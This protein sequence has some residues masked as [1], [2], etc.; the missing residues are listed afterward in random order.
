MAV[1]WAVRQL[2]SS[3]GGSPFTVAVAIGF[4]AVAG[5]CLQLVEL[6][7]EVIHSLSPFAAEYFQSAGHVGVNRISLTPGLTKSGLV[8]LVGYVTF[9]TTMLHVLRDR[10]VIDTVLRYVALSA[11]MM[12]VIGIAQMIAGNGEFLWVFKHPLRSA[13]G[14]AKGTFTNQNHFAHFLALGVGPLIWCWLNSGLHEGTNVR[15]RVSN[16]GF[17]VR[18]DTDVIQM[19]MAVGIGVVALAGILSMSRGGIAA[20]LVAFC[21]SLFAAGSQPAKVLR[22]CMS[23]G[24][25]FRL[26][27]PIILLTIVG[28]TA[29]GTEILEARWA[30]LSQAQ[31][32]QDLSEGRYLLWAALWK[33]VPWFWPLGSGVGSH[34][35]VYPTWLEEDFGKRFSHAESGY[36]QVLIETGI[37]GLLLVGLAIF[38]VASWFFRVWRAGN[39]KDR[40]RS[41]V[42][43]S[44]LVVSSLHSVADFVWYIPACMVLTL[45]LAACL[46]RQFQLVNQETQA[47]VSNSG[48]R[49]CQRWPMIWACV[50]VVAVVPT[51]RLTAGVLVSNAQT[52]QEWLKYRRLAIDASADAGFGAMEPL[53]QRLTAMIRHLER[54][55]EIE[56][57][58]CLARCELAGLYLRRFEKHQLAIANPVSVA[59]I[60]HTVLNSEFESSREVAEWLERAFGE[61]ALDLY[62]SLA[63]SRTAM[64]GQPLRGETISC[65]RN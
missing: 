1:A 62:R 55:V 32:F 19:W 13:N 38:L 53:D 48:S 41:A 46:C 23:W 54:C 65:F 43:M 10:A 25:F 63:M 15:G 58:N 28:V 37:F 50:V 5:V 2:V 16:R 21:I 35:E 45:I 36:L 26:L 42:L 49:P 14:A 64:V 52:E 30:R 20:L 40:Q 27:V 39:S 47:S 59:E 60:R 31:S 17:G 51:T 4:F 22:G 8:L 33:A 34:A 3:N 44:G 18:R 12:A 6:P 56:P 24:V 57:S 7:I 11:V 61:S 29:F 9:F